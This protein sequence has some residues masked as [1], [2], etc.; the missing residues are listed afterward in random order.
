[1]SGK[2]DQQS[3]VID[4]EAYEDIHVHEV[5]EAIAEHFSSTRHKPWPRVARFLQGQRPGSVGVDIG[6]GNGKYQPVNETVVLLGCDACA[7]LVRLARLERG[8]EVV[9]ADGLALPYRTCRADFA[10]CIAVVHHFSTRERRRAAIGEVLSCLRAGDE[11]SRALLYV[12]ALEQSSS[13]RGWDVGSDPDALVPWVARGTTYQRY[14]HL[15]AQ[16][17][18]DQDVVAAGGEVVESG[19]ERD[20][21]WVVCRR[22]C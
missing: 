5:Y 18:L 7:S 10:I 4:D 6:C 22:V 9:T 14:Y 17:E 13:R 15:Y 21:W 16:G 11:S 3:S 8:A 19:Y 1:M 20:N 12:W 2:P